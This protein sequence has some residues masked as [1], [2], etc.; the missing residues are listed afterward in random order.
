MGNLPYTVR[1][2]YGGVAVKEGIQKGQG[3]GVGSKSIEK[4][5]G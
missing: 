1:L 5:R 2:K 3:S 4:G